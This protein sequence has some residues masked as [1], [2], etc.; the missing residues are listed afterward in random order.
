MIPSLPPQNRKSGDRDACGRTESSLC[1]QGP[2]YT[3]LSAL[4][5]SASQCCLPSGCNVTRDASGDTSSLIIQ[6]SEGE[7]LSM[8]LLKDEQHFPSSC[9]MGQGAVCGHPNTGPWQGAWNA[10][11]ESCHSRVLGARMGGEIC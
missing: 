9:P 5:S 1:L 6:G 3:Q 2:R 8:S 4:L 10:G 7:A 11:M